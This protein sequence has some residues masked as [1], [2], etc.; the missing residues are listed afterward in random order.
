MSHDEM[1]D[2]KTQKDVRDTVAEET[3]E[4]VRDT[5]AE[6]TKENNIADDLG[7]DKFFTEQAKK[8]REKAD[9]IVEDNK[10]TGAKSSR[11]EQ[12]S[13]TY[14]QHNDD[15]ASTEIG[16]AVFNKM[17]RKP[18]VTV[19]VIGAVILVGILLYTLAQYGSNQSEKIESSKML[20]NQSLDG[21][22]SGNVS[23]PEYCNQNPHDQRLCEL[24]WNLKFM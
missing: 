1:N 5:V 22:R 6:E 2:E 4:D 11:I 8:L 13:D 3:K 16:K 23:V 10:F 12:E 21:L 14:K 20:W 18:I 17:A 15:R 19:L 9:E 7:E 24:Y